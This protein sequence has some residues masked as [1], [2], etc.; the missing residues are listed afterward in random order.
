ML[1]RARAFSIGNVMKTK[2]WSQRPPPWIF[3]ITVLPYGVFFGFITTSMPYLLRSAGVSVERI[4]GIGA[5]ALAP[6]VWYFLW[7]P[8]ADVGLRKRTWLIL[9]SALS[10][11]CLGAALWLPPTAELNRFVV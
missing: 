2:A 8:L 5:L 6:P 4:A 1:R 9:T 11:A 10:S 3:G 7:A